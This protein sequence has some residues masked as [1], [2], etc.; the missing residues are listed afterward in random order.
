M[1]SSPRRRWNLC[2][3]CQA[4]KYLNHLIGKM[5]TIKEIG[6]SIENVCRYHKITTEI[7]Y[8]RWIKVDFVLINVSHFCVVCM[9][10]VSICVCVHVMETSSLVYVCSMGKVSMQA[11]LYCNVKCVDFF[12]YCYF[13]SLEF[14]NQKLSL[15]QGKCKKM[16]RK[17]KQNTTRRKVKNRRRHGSSDTVCDIFYVL[18]FLFPQM[19]KNGIIYTIDSSKFSDYSL[20]LYSG[21]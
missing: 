9:N 5:C 19:S 16:K 13:F 1:F 2:S 14:P 7:T 18:L 8:A 3:K 11:H 20:Y 15:W 6:P 4:N 17:T 12:E 21:L 10:G